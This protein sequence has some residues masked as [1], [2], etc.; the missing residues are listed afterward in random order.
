MQS[1]MYHQAHREQETH[2]IRLTRW[3]ITR[4]K[5]TRITLKRGKGFSSSI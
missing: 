2:V 1:G 4:L 3:G 5:I